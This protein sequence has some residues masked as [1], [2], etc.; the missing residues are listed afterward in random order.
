MFGFWRRY[1]VAT[2]CEAWGAPVLTHAT[3]TR[4]EFYRFKG[5]LTLRCAACHDTHVKR[6]ADLWLVEDEVGDA[7][8]ERGAETKRQYPTPRQ[9]AE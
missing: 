7:D 1:R 3:M 4:R 8:P 9:A 2:V 6:A 5:E